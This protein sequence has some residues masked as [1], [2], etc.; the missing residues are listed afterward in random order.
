[1]VTALAVCNRFVRQANVTGINTIRLSLNL[2]AIYF[3][4]ARWHRSTSW[5]S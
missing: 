3:Q 2:M 5:S 4:I 1:M